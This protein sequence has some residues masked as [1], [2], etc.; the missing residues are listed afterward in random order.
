MALISINRNPSK[1]ELQWF[2]LLTAAF[3]VFLGAVVSWWS[4]WSPTPF[5]A[6][7]AVGV[8]FGVV[9]Y[10]VRSLRRP[11]YLGWMR[12]VYP[13]GWV[14]SHLMLGLVYFV[15]MTPIGLFMRMIGRDALNLPFDRGANTYWTPRKR[16]SSE[17][18]FRQF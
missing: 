3:F 17:R 5:V 1:S 14:I 2:G 18:Y 8:T 16:A 10:G 4:G 12:A 13:I 11:L 9:Y 7:A 15:V 6:L